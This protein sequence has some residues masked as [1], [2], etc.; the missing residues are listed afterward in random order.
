MERKSLAAIQERGGAKA[1]DKTMVDALE[2]AVKALEA[3]MENTL[4]EAARAAEEAARNGMENTK[5]YTARFGRAKSLLDRAVGHQD[6]G[7]TSVWLIF[8]GMREYIEGI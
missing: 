4:L 2:P 6:A 3:N 1:G 5:K 7:A 8:Q